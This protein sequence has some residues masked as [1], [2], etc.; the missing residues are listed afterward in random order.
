LFPFPFVF[1][2][3]FLLFVSLLHPFPFSSPC[4]GAIGARA[5]DRLERQRHPGRRQQGLRHQRMRRNYWTRF[6][7]FVCLSVSLVVCFFFFFFCLVGCL[8]VLFV[9][10]FACLFVAS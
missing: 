4:S 3:I 8:F 10:L 5:S 9:C 7:L 2:P 6:R 1:H